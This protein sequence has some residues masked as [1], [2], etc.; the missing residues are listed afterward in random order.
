MSSLDTCN[1]L[2]SDIVLQVCCMVF[3]LR[4]PPMNVLDVCH[5]TGRVF[6]ANQEQAAVDAYA[7]CTSTQK[8]GYLLQ[9]QMCRCHFLE[10]LMLCAYIAC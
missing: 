10:Y 7:W 9:C 3:C 2:L 4:G 1:A 5:Q 8:D 6:V